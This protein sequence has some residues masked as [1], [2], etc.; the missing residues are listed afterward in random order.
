MWWILNVP[1]ACV[2]VC[3][4]F[5]SSIRTGHTFKIPNQTRTTLTNLWPKDNSGENNYVATQLMGQ[6]LMI[7]YSEVMQD[8]TCTAISLMP[9][10]LI[11][12]DSISW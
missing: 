5:S 9:M 1:P 11:Y 2:Y 10:N 12:I 8:A 4:S 6:H 3:D 7:W